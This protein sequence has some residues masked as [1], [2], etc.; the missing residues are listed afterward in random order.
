MSDLRSVLERADEAVSHV[1]L[2]VAGLDGIR[3]RRDRKRRN[4]RIGA[5]VVG[6][7]VFLVAIWVVTSG[8]PAHRG[9][10]PAATGPTVAT[11]PKARSDY[12]GQVGLVGIAPEDAAS[13]LP[14]RGEL[15]VGAFFTHTAGDPGRFALSV[16]ADGRV[17]WEKLGDTSSGVPTGPATGLVEQR[18][19]P[20]G[21]ELVRSE[22]LSVGP[23]RGDVH[24]VGAYALY[25]GMVQVR[26]GDGLVSISWGDVRPAHGS[27]PETAA[28]DQQISALQALDAELEDLESWL[29]AS[30]WADAEL[31]AFVPSRYSLCLQTGRAVE[32]DQVLAS[33]PR[34]AGDA[35]RA[36]DLSYREHE[37]PN[38]PERWHLWCSD[39]TSDRAREL[40]RLLDDA[41]VPSDPPDVFGHTYFIDRSRADDFGV[42]IF[43]EAELPD[44]P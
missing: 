16:Y 17:I 9:L 20:D 25:A 30:A 33:L 26:G 22:V 39:V 29:P 38:P 12:P 10:T 2:P 13:S 3:R 19:T 27:P 35:L 44:A 4:T 8:A 34:P 15:V 43:F 7:A 11:G 1:P 32:L 28:T 40:S 37:N 41:G 42:T 24:L 6:V 5:G 21:V 31:R 14:A 23:F 18:L 36:W